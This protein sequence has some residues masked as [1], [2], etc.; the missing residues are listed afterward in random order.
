MVPIA[1]VSSVFKSLSSSFDKFFEEYKS[2]HDNP[3]VKKYYEIKNKFDEILKAERPVDAATASQA[4]AVARQVEAE[5]AVAEEAARLAAVKQAAAERQA[6]AGRLAAA[7]QAKEEAARGEAARQAAKAKAA[8][9][10][11]KEEEARVASELTDDLTHFKLEVVN[12]QDIKPGAS[13]GLRRKPL[14]ETKVKNFD[15]LIQ[16]LSAKFLSNNI[17]SLAKKYQT[18]TISVLYEDDDWIN[19]KDSDEKTLD[20]IKSILHN[21]GGIY[22]GKIRLKHNDLSNGRIEKAIK[23]I[24]DN[25]KATRR[26][27][28]VWEE[29]SRINASRKADGG[30]RRTKRKTKSKRKRKRRTKNKSRKRL[31]RKTLKKS[32]KKRSVK[33]RRKTRKT[34][35]KR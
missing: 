12:V 19:L 34:L 16:A 17:R 3:E 29:V 6:E 22:R 33:K 15:E 23:K 35:K 5:T 14:L 30:K 10:A 25:L 7:R 4:E 9:K 2:S 24:K 8:A 20:Y 27:V 1:C 31:T 26:G 13:P 11:R 21:E 28:E 32:I 18:L